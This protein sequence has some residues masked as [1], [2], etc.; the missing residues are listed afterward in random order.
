MAPGL[1]VP[2]A[3]TLVLMA[4]GSRDPR[5]RQPFQALHAEL[6]TRLGE[7]RV[8]LCYMEM[9]EP[10]LFA[11]LRQATAQGHARFRVLPLFMAAGAHVANDI[12]AQVAQ[13]EAMFPGT[14]YETL[15]PVG[16]HP[17]VREALARIA[18]EAAD[19]T[20]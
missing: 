10:D 17:A 7:G 6:A 11:V 2:N 14:T 5:W 12:T 16:E 13:A 15:P 4:H 19:S 1:N 18:L 8:W 20:S 9:A 3:P